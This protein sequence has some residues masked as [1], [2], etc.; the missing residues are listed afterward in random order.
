MICTITSAEIIKVLKPNLTQGSQLD[1]AS[2]LGKKAE[3]PQGLH[4][5]VYTVL[6]ITKQSVLQV[7]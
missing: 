7:L 1:E 2:I 3:S 4:L 5:F 6:N